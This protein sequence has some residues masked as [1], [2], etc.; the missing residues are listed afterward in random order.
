MEQK[1]IFYIHTEIFNDVN[2]SDENIKDFSKKMNL[3]FEVAR[4]IEAEVYYPSA[5]ITQLKDFFEN[6][7]SDFTQSQANRLD[8]LLKDFI[9]FNDK[10]SFF[11]VHF[12][13]E[14]TSLEYVNYSFLNAVDNATAINIVFTLSNTSKEQLL[15]VHS[16]ESFYSIEINQCNSANNIWELINQSLPQRTYNFSSKHG[17]STT[18]ASPPNREKVSQLLCSDKD[19]QELL[20]SAIYDKREKLRFYYNF[21]KIHNTFIIFP[22]EGNTPQNQFHA[23]HIEEVE[24]AK[25]IPASIKK[26]FNT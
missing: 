24:W 15:L 13:S 10:Y 20:N 1:F 8:L 19:A 18:K 12:A 26:Y 23:F 14:S 25:E 7:D 3:I 6:F 11:K 16:N 17:N 9:P 5:A 21:D 22:F 4:Q 2:F